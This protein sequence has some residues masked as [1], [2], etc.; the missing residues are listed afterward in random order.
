M[1]KT[2]TT[3]YLAGIREGR[4]YLNSHKPDVQEMT[5]ILANVRETAKLFSAGPVKDMLK[6]E[7]DFWINQIKK[8]G[9]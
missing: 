5:L 2:V 7:R 4:E 3:E 6:G 1:A 9:N 8:E